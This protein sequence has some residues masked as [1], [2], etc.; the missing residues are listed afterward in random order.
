MVKMTIREFLQ[1][2]LGHDA[3]GH[4][5]AHAE[6]VVAFAKTIQAREGGD[7]P[8][9]EGCALLHDCL[10][11]KLG[12]DNKKQEGHVYQIL[13]DN[14]FGEERSKAMIKTM[15][16][17]SF[18]LHDETDLTLEDMIVRDADR[19]DAIGR[20]GAKR[21]IA[22]GNAHGRPFVSEYNKEELAAGNRPTGQ[23]TLAHF[24]DKLLILDR[25]LYTNTAK[26]LA[27]PLKRELI[28]SLQEML[29]KEGIELPLSLIE[30]L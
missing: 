18:H 8:Y 16:R 1:H 25:H 11:S 2:E 12:L 30:S 4:D 21:A 27:V 29:S 24:F 17:M 6:R 26:E 19:L 13:L 10:D 14:G 23:S 7:W 3:S 9:I 28:D 15:G 5:V 20:V 22:Y